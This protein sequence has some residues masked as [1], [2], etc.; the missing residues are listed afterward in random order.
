MPRTRIRGGAV[1]TATACLLL[2]S[3]ACSSPGGADNAP[4]RTAA[5]GAQDINTRPRTT[6]RDGGELR[7]P[8]DALPANYNPVQVN[9]TRVVN[10]QLS[11][12]ILPRTPSDGADGEPVLNRAFFESAKLTSTSP[13]TITYTIAEGPV[14]NNDRPLSWEDLRGQWRALSGSDAAYEGY[15]HVGYADE[16]SA[17]GATNSRVRAG[18]ARSRAT[19]GHRRGRAR[20]RARRAL[21]RGRPQDRASTCGRPPRALHLGKVGPGMR[22]AVRPQLRPGDDLS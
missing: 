10:W 18:T 8:V 2:L 1:A 22:T 15:N 5:R 16:P 3:S 19:R 12:A 14:R 20:V 17:G 7:L 13:R 9:D 6:L 21:P 11:G 4:L